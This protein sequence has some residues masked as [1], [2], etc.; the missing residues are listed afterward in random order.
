MSDQIEFA[1][2]RRR[3]RFWRITLA[4][5]VIAVGG[6]AVWKQA[7]MNRPQGDFNCFAR[8]A[9]AIR[10]CNA[11][12]YRVQ[13]DHGWH[14]NYPP[15][16]A[17]LMTPFADPPKQA[18]ALLASSILGQTA[19][20]AGPLFAAT[21]LPAYPN[22]IVVDPGPYLP[23]PLSIALFYL[24]N[25]AMLFAA[26]HL[27]V[28]AIEHHVPPARS[29]DEANWRWWWW[30]IGPGL[31]CAPAIGLTLVR[32]Q[33][34]TLLLLL[35]CGLIVGLLRGRRLV[36]G[37][38][39]AAAICLKLFPGFLILVPLA[40][41]D[42]R[43]LAGC[44]LGLVVGLVIVPLVVMGPQQ[45]AEVYRDYASLLLGPAL[46]F[47][48]DQMRA[49]ELLNA[50]ATQSQAFQVVL[51]K[52]LY[53]GD[54]TM[55]PEPAVWVKLLHLLLGGSMTLALLRRDG[56]LHRA[57]GLAL[58]ARIGLL[59]VLMTLLCPVCHLHYFTLLVPLIT[60][61]VVKRSVV[62]PDAAHRDLWTLGIL[63]VLALSLPMIPGLTVLRDVGVPMYAVLVWWFAGFATRWPIWGERAAVTLPR[64]A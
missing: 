21:A 14:Y 11:S 44:A 45:T 20:P 6:L 58:V 25:V 19:A 49:A 23:Y 62:Q 40:R 35:G 60:A 63:L 56:G 5:A 42:G 43:C 16:F 59:A 12:L 52:T 4:L 55:P 48:L 13:D 57:D 38:C 8:G 34:Q 18:M 54:V 29:A 39:I 10:Q 15:L 50:T 22:P 9:W 24:L 26:V 28:S 31:A 41:R 2:C 3:D 51:H 53:L 64:A 27:L 46:G 7:L 61:M 33:V 1:R 30:R 37:L 17:I 36:A 32:G 47:S